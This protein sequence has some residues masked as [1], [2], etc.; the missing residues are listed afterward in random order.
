MAFERSKH[1]ALNDIYSVVLNV[2][3]CNNYMTTQRVVFPLN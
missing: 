3:L 1:V 2:Y